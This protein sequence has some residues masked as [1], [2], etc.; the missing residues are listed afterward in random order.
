MYPY[1]VSVLEM[2]K[3]MAFFSC[4][5]VAIIL[6]IASL[7]FIPVILGTISSIFAEET[8]ASPPLPTREKEIVIPEVTEMIPEKKEGIVA[9]IPIG[10]KGKTDQPLLRI[11]SQEFLDYDEE[12]N[13][14]Y[15]RA[16]TRVWYK[17][18]YLEADRLVYDVRLNEVQA[19]GD[20]ILKTKE[21][22]YRADS[23]WYSM[24]NGRGYAYGASGRRRNIFIHSDPREKENPAFQLLGQTDNHKP[25]EAL[26]R[27][28]SYTTCDFPVPHYRIS[29]SEILLYPDDRI[30]LRGAT[31][32]VWDVPVFYL[33]VY[34]RSLK[35]SFPWS[36]YVGYASELGGYLRIAYDYYHLEQEPDI[37]DEK[38]W[39]KKSSG[40]LSAYMDFF[41]KRGMGIGG[42]Y[43]YLL[44]YD[45]HRGMID[46][47]GISDTK[48]EIKDYADPDTIE[49]L[50]PFKRWMANIEH[51]SRLSDTLSFQL[52]IDEMSDPDV[53]YDLLDRFNDTKRNRIPERNI[54]TALNYQKEIYIARLHFQI[55]NRIGRDRSANFANPEDNDQDYD[56]DPFRREEV[57][58]Y[59]GYI[60]NRY[61]LVS[62][63]LPQL[64]L[65]SNYLKLGEFP[66]YTYTDI[67]I[68][69]NLDKGLNTVGRDD[70]A[71]VR[72]I[73][74]YQ[75]ILHRIRL[76]RNYTFTTRLGFGASS[77]VRENSD[78]N[79]DFPMGTAFPY[80]QPGEEGGLTFLDEDTFLVGRRYYDNS[81]NL[82]TTSEEL[83]DWQRK[84]QDDT[85]KYYLYSDLMLYLHGR[86]TNYLN[87]W[88]RYDI[89]EGTEDSLGEFYE[90]LGNV[91]SRHDLYNFR[92]PRHWISSG[93]DHFL[94]YPNITT[95]LSA[96]YN[97]QSEKDIN[98]NE[99]LYFTS[100]GM[101]YINNP[102]TFKLDTSVRY[103]G[104][105]KLD[106]SDPLESSLDYIY[107]IMNAQYIPLSKSWWTK[108]TIS[109]H[110]TLTEGEE[111]AIGYGFSEYDPELD[112]AGLL[113]A[114]IGPK[115]I[116][117]G[118]IVYKERI[119][120][121]GIS[122]IG[123]VIKRDLHDFLA[124]L[125]IGLKRDVRKEQYEDDKIEGDMD[126]DIHFTLQ[127]K[128][129]FQKSSM[130]A[131]TIRT[132]VDVASETELTDGESSLPLF[133]GP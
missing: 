106:P 89:R 69:N 39:V 113:G 75:G 30:F 7:F 78:F 115:Y 109:S 11:T 92:L 95:Q 29:C 18:V 111:S 80:D 61:G 22:E 23:L 67:N 62:K 68:I 56:I 33:P 63:R 5:K 105:Q 59:E 90:S 84:N 3:N 9:K 26:F 98:P 43:K 10:P 24:D 130:G 131:A 101:K 41:S 99:E 48:F 66:F 47:Y 93:F 73:D 85:E 107:G 123:A 55:R 1:L 12:S 72:G 94:L 34:T 126:W 49:E 114:K 21:D 2:R 64:T 81:G 121:N 129:P 125:M 104:R 25:R 16:R 79:Y 76:S 70:D 71:W 42:K 132:L 17:D 96:G 102:E 51:R 86:I 120:D 6:S 4:K 118:R 65:S 87:G 27:N 112:V 57:D 15:G 108:V 116:V 74:L 36:F 82:L 28:S 32:Y 54:Q 38:D 88:I 44:E 53:Y 117:E 100:L 46:L 119:A 40:H 14:I 52:G 37:H 77:M 128:S 20:I 91:L 60:H 35:E 133:V 13:F 97:L 122:Y 19:Y 127:V 8:G 58:K 103:S 83:E 110:R 124:S 50:D 45:R 31:F